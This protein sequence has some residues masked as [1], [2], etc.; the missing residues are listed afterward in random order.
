MADSSTTVV[1]IFDLS[2]GH[3]WARRQLLTGIQDITVSSMLMKSLPTLGGGGSSE[4]YE[5]ILVITELDGM[6][7]HNQLTDLESVTWTSLGSMPALRRYKGHLECTGI[8]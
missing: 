2:S 7:L 8:H 6:F 4:G 1:R 3:H 5:G